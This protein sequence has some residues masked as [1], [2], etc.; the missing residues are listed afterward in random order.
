MNNQGLICRNV[1]FIFD[2]LCG[3]D[4]THLGEEEA[5]GEDGHELYVRIGFARLEEHSSHI[6][7]GEERI[8]LAMIVISLPRR[9]QESG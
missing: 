4:E 5:I 7:G 9:V 3:V 8:E 2:F 1:V 6:R